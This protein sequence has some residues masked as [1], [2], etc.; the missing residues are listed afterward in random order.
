MRITAIRLKHLPPFEE[1]LLKFP[2]K[3]E[4]KIGEVQIIT[5]QN[6]TG[7]TRLLCALASALGNGV[8]LRR[9]IGPTAVDFCVS[10]ATRNRV[11]VHVFNSQLGVFSGEVVADSSASILES[12]DTSNLSRY[13]IGGAF[14]P[15]DFRLRL[16]NEELHCSALAVRGTNKISDAAVEAMKAIPT[17][18]YVSSIDFDQADRSLFVLQAIT[19]L[20]MSS[21]MEHLSK[22]SDNSITHSRSTRIITRIEAA[23]TTITGKKFAFEIVPHPAVSIRVRWGDE[24]ISFGA[25]PDGLRS[26]IGFL[27]LCASHLSVDFPEHDSPLDISIVILMDEP[28]T[29]LHPAWQQRLIPAAQLLMQNSQ[30]FV[31][32][33]SPFVVSSV[34]SGFVHVLTETAGKITVSKAVPCSKG[35]TW[36]DAVE[37]ALGLKTWYDPE[38]E[39]MLAKFRD[40]KKEV[41]TSDGNMSELQ[42]LAS[43]IASRSESL[44]NIM[45]RE[46]Y[47]LKNFKGRVAASQ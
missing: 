1:V 45:A 38:T 19:N 2:E 27:V 36:I 40:I 37:D 12:S 33:H 28:E 47:Q 25:L 20:K 34:N 4:E 35:D 30:L 41:M 26:V 21:A 16:S 8:N 9:R 7:K 13:Y 15:K 10:V 3:Q 32:T 11:F 5:G 31:V 44:S 43:D 46:M 17:P 18:D 29:H 42:S 24:K 14:D 6:G 23:I 39:S 22:E